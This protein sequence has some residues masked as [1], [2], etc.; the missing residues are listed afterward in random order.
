MS[1]SASSVTRRQFVR[2]AAVASALPLVG[3]Q[4]VAAAW[5]AERH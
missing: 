5:V 2:L 1:D 3:R 4:V